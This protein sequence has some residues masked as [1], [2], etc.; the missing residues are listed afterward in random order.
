MTHES[1]SRYACIDVGTN[2][3]KILIAE[4]GEE[5]IE[6]VFESSQTTRIG[7]GMTPN[8]MRLREEPMRR[9]LETLSL[10]MEQAKL[11]QTK[12]IT[13]VGTAALRDAENRDDFLRRVSQRCGLKIEI[14][15]GEEEEIGKASCRERV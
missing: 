2:S 3:I 4:K 6:R 11:F 12:E 10:F 5:A 9:S 15:P 8:S 13:A 7:Q 14:I 1:P